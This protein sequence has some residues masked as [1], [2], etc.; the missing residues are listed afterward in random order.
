MT[1]QFG[2]EVVLTTLSSRS[3]HP[4]D[5]RNSDIARQRLT[6]IGRS[7]CFNFPE[8]DAIPAGNKSA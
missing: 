8:G 6:L 3:G 5:R 2:R 1:A 4:I 7:E